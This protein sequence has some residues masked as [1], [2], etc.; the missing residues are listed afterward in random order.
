MMVIRTLL[1]LY[2]YV[3]IVDAILSYFPNLKD[4]NW[5]KQLKRA[6]DFSCDP[7]R[8]H[9]PPHLPFDFSPILV[10][11]AIELFFFLW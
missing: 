9:L 8:K 4:Q 11:L 2:I 10:I 3:L 5:R 7:V 6:A 1:Q